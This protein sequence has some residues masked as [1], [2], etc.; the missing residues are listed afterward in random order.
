MAMIDGRRW[1]GLESQ[2][3]R[4]TVRALVMQIPRLD[5]NSRVK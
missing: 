2:E 3:W 4:K 1:R 5:N